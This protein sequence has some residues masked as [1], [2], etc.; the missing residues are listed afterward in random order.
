MFVPLSIPFLE[1][2]FGSKKWRQTSP[3]PIMAMIPEFREFED[4]QVSEILNTSKFVNI[5]KFCSLDC[6]FSSS[7]S[8]RVEFWI[9]FLN[10]EVSDVQ[11]SGI[12]EFEAF[13]KI[14]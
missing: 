1:H 9:Q 13:G 10:Y 12:K 4:Q 6:C 8:I 5:L 14:G 7:F 2:A 3:V 11:W